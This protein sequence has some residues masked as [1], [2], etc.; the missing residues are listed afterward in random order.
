MMVVQ[1]VGLGTGRLR[2]VT[3]H[4]LLIETEPSWTDGRSLHLIIGW[5][6][7]LSAV[8][9]LVVQDFCGIFGDLTSARG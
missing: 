9:L 6:L 5:L 8:A 1:K 2:C 7:V 4:P 3:R